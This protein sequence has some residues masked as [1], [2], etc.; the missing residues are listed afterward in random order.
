MMPPRSRTWIV[1]EEDGGTY[2]LQ[3]RG[4]PLANG[5]SDRAVHRKLRSRVKPSDKLLIEE[6]DGYRRPG[7]LSDF[8]DHRRKV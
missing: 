6:P 5:L 7:R 1:V 3:L 8:L 4:R 2:E